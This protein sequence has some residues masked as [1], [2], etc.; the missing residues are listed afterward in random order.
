MQDFKS[1]L[2][3]L[4]N[5]LSASAKEKMVGVATTAD[6]NNPPIIFG[7]TRETETTIAVTIILRDTSFVDE[8]INTFDGVAD[9]FMIDPEVKNEA[10]NLESV[11]LPKI[12]KSK[13]FI[14]KPNDFTVDSLDTLVALLFGTLLG[15]KV[16]II[17]AG[18]IGSKIALK[19]C[20]RGA[21]VFL[22]DKDLEKTKTIIEGLKLVKR[23]KCLILAS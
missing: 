8:I 15:K 11:I 16:L 20:E 13:Y 12:K 18:N 6:I 2:E 17:G 10:G 1:K 4:K 14:Y 21:N 19:L 22:F 7:S 3:E 23:S 5:I 9:Y